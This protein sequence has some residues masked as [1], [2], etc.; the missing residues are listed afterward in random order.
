MPN[1]R[2]MR[3]F[4][5]PP[6][7]GASYRIASPRGNVRRFSLVV[8]RAAI[9]NEPPTTNNEHV[10]RLRR[11]ALPLPGP[12]HGVPLVR[13]VRAAGDDVPDLR[14]P[15][16]RKRRLQADRIAGGQGRRRRDPALLRRLDRPR[17]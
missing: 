17:E 6:K 1:S 12:A 2:P 4:M 14:R 11:L 15:V 9:Y 10:P 8:R 16:L 13:Q 3:F 5:L 7:G